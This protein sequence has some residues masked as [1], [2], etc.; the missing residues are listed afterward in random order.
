MNDTNR[1]N[2]QPS[3]RPNLLT[4]GQLHEAGY[5]SFSINWQSDAVFDHHDYG[6]CQHFDVVGA[7]PATPGLYAFTVAR[8]DRLDV[9]YVGMT[10]DLWMVTKGRRSSGAPRGG[11]HYGRPRHAGVTRQ[12]VNSA[13]TADPAN[14]TA[15]MW[16]RPE[17]FARSDEL[18]HLEE[19]EISRWGLR[20]NGLNRG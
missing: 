12:R 17:R 9:R 18:R 2:D 6:P 19:R 7:V 4:E 1:T 20:R 15:L 8:D 5:E 13:L 16:L 14:A 11:Q 10:T 3:E